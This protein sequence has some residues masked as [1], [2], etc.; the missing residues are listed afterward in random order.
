MERKSL[1][2]WLI[3]F[4]ALVPLF[5]GSD[6]HLQLATQLL[7]FVILFIGVDIAVGHAGLVSVAHG[8]LFGV[9]AYAT[10][11]LTV[12]HGLNFWLS[13]PVGIALAAIFGLLIGIL[14]LKLAGHYFVISTMAF[15]LL[16]H[17]AAKN[18][19]ITHGELGITNIAKPGVLELFTGNQALSFYFLMAIATLVVVVVYFWLMRSAFGRRLRAIRDNPL[20][21][22]ALG[23]DISTAKLLAFV[24]SASIAAFAGSF[25]AVFLTY[26]NPAVTGYELGFTALMALII[27]G[28][29][30]LGGIIVGAFIFAILPE[31]L[32]DAEQYRLVIMGA[33]L[34]VVVQRAPSGIY[35]KLVDWAGLLR[36]RRT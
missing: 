31:M 36:K 4:F 19:P 5:S 12:D 17:T 20:L 18:L 2:V 27:G 8:A 25:H 6:Y 16:I 28:R 26:I 13:I 1:W 15:A 33:I 22:D 14:T 30:T 7:I 21:A 11:I 3:V 35:G 24:A 32:R 9:G 34:I 10:A 23:I 29:T